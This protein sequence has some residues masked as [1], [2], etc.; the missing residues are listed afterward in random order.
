MNIIGFLKCYIFFYF[1]LINFVFF[2]PQNM[3]TRD[4]VQ[5]KLVIFKKYLYLKR[6][7]ENGTKCS[8]KVS[9]GGTLKKGHFLTFKIAITFLIFIQIKK[10]KQFCKSHGRL[11]LIDWKNTHFVK[12]IVWPGHPI[13]G[14]S[15]I[16]TYEE[17]NIYS[18]VIPLFQLIFYGELISGLLFKF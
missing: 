3:P 4:D 15:K 8:V 2:F 6:Y 9:L 17:V 14:H 10:L 7:R 1:F 12:L 5:W 13:R 11:H 16:V 18:F